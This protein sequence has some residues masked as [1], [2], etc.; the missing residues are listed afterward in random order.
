MKK[1]VTLLLALVLTTACCAALADSTYTIFFPAEELAGTTEMNGFVSAMG[2]TELNTLILKDDGTYELTKLLGTL[3]E[4]HE[5]VG[6]EAE[7]TPVPG[8]EVC[9]VYTGAYTQDGDQVTLNIPDECVFSENWSVLVDSGYMS[10]SA[11]TASNGDRVV[12]YEGTD[13]DPMDNFGGPV[14]KFYGHDTAINVTVNADGTYTY[15]AVASSDD[16]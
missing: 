6:F 16:D 9:Y 10:N 8:V 12:N 2:M 3:D 15:N 5:V 14:Y 1:I 4:A 7:G 11:G 13:F